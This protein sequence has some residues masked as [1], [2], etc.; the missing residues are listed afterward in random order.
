[1]AKKSKKIFTTG[2]KEINLQEHKPG[3]NQLLFEHNAF[4]IS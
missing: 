1:M 3:L 2:D 4:T